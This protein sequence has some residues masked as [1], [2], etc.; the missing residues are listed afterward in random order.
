MLE[1]YC[2]ETL[3]NVCRDVVDKYNPPLIRLK[4]DKTKESNNPYKNFLGEYHYLY[5]RSVYDCGR[6]NRSRTHDLCRLYFGENLS[7]ITF[8]FFSD[9][10]N[11]QIEN[12]MNQTG[13]FKILLNQF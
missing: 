11:G 1:K 13:D 2:Y 12:A 8:L 5:M 9:L 6:G 10:Y 7:N 4:T 3:R